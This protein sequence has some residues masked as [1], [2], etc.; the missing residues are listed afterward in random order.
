MADPIFQWTGGYDPL[1]ARPSTL[2]QSKG[3]ATVASKGITIP[4]PKTGSI[5]YGSGPDA[6]TVSG[7]KVQGPTEDVIA[8]REQ[9][10]ILGR[11]VDPRF[12][13]SL[14]MPQAKKEQ[15]RQTPSVLK[16]LMERMQALRKTETNPFEQFKNK[17][18]PTAK[19]FEARVD[20]V[21]ISF[22]NYVKDAVGLEKT[23]SGETEELARQSAAYGNYKGAQKI[24]DDAEQQRIDD[25]TERELEDTQNPPS[26]SEKVA[27][28]LTQGI[29]YIAPSILLTRAAGAKRL[30]DFGIK[31]MIA[32]EATESFAFATLKTD[33]SQINA[34]TTPA[35]LENLSD[36]NMNPTAKAF[37]DDFKFA[38]P[39][40]VGLN[41]A[42]NTLVPAAAKAFKNF[43]S[44]AQESEISLS[45]AVIRSGLEGKPSEEF[46]VAWNALSDNDRGAIEGLW[47]QKR[48]IGESR[49]IFLRDPNLNNPGTPEFGKPTPRAQ[50]RSDVPQVFRTDKL[51]LDEDGL[52]IVRAKLGALGLET[53][54][55]QTFDEMKEIADQLGM[56]P[57]K[58]IRNIVDDKISAGEVVAL[59]DSIKAAVDFK[60]ASHGLME[61]AITSAEKEAVVL[62]LAQNDQLLS[63]SINQLV[64]GGT[65]AGRAVV[66]YRIIARDTLDPTFWL[67][68][69]RKIV[70]EERW[71]KMG[72]KEFDEVVVGI[73]DLITKKDKLGLAYFVAGLKESG[74]A[75]KMITL[76]KAGLLTSPTTHMANLMGNTTMQALET[77]KDIPATLIDWAIS[78]LTGTRTKAMT[79]QGFV[80]QTK[81]LMKGGQKAVDYMKTGIDADHSLTKYDIPR[82]VNFNNAFL[83]AYTDSVFR[84]LGGSDK[85]FREGILK[86]SLYEQAALHVK[87]L[88]SDELKIVAKDLSAEYGENVGR[89]DIAEFFFKNPHD[90]WVKI[91]ID[92][93]EY[94]TFLR[95]NRAATMISAAKK[96]GG[97]GG[98]TVMEIT[99]PFVRTPTNVA[100]TIWDYSPAGFMNALVAGLKSNQKKF[101][102]AMGRGITGTSIMALGAALA[103]EGKMTSSMPTTDKERKLWKTNGITQQSIFFDGKWRRLDRMSPLGN[104]LSIG[105]EFNRIG[106]DRTVGER[107]YATALG[108]LKGLTEQS[109]LRGVSQG[110][111]AIMQP[112]R[113]AEAFVYNTIA[114]VVPSVISRIAQGIDPLERDPETLLETIGA[115]LPILSEFVP[116]EK[117]LFGRDMPNTK[118][119]FGRIFDP[120]SSSSPTGDPVAAE[121]QILQNPVSVPAKSLYSNKEYADLIEL[122]GNM[123]YPVLYSLMNSEVYQKQWSDD[124]RRYAINSISASATQEAN[125]YMKQKLALRLSQDLSKISPEER[126]LRFKRIQKRDN[127]L[128]QMIEVIYS[129]Q[130]EY[131]R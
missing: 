114:S 69:A 32:Q 20:D 65:E 122:R 36:I 15:L 38:F 96:A 108:G 61:E 17:R 100:M 12:Q 128:S 126:D 54:G 59:R 107:Y 52:N 11:S 131:D 103:Q 49:P 102:E 110:L 98:R 109:F 67:K 5:V 19:I 117:D 95:D 76:W 13:T 34:D 116:A 72:Q 105:A 2:G 31:G 84:A 56:D 88:S 47:K 8:Y 9:Q 89:K 48:M 39:G 62:R 10:K 129:S 74:G 77:A 78:P 41:V 42:G 26:T 51:N 118:G 124:Q 60:V 25:M 21:M 66:A 82:T 127:T 112:E 91:A 45:P 113:Y 92:D 93:A 119:L 73:N 85:I 4:P 130:P 27:R 86:K 83:Q 94:A 75:E 70:G 37:W 111:N 90:D 14:S 33:L 121:L 50:P 18:I 80:E 104:L 6:L 7:K 125:N 1:A 55:V 46:A 81:G 97:T 22:R 16:R 58:M 99:M 68:E 44:V 101:V 115:R 3:T 23:G 24:M 87:S 28:G 53:R 106:E 71:T 123:L 30:G 35:N 43:L 29:A 57:E 63:D 64:K 79:L 120:F 40:V